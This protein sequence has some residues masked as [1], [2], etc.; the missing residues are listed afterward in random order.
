MKL[1][2]LK[3]E[4]EFELNL[5]VEELKEKATEDLKNYLKKLKLNLGKAGVLMVKHKSSKSIPH[6]IELHKVKLSIQITEIEE[7]IEARQ[8]DTKKTSTKKINTKFTINQKYQIIRQMGVIA[9]MIDKFEENLQHQIFSELFEC[10]IDTSRK[11]L[12]GTYKETK[13]VRPMDYKELLNKIKK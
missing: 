13:E 9:L 2:Q 1:Q 11:I 3:E 12:S 6:H 10:H 4:F 7:I 8:S 5:S